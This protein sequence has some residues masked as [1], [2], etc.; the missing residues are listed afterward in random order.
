MNFS[1]GVTPS[2]IKHSEHLKTELFHPES[3]FWKW[4]TIFTYDT[5]RN[6]I[7]DNTTSLCTRVTPWL[8]KRE[9]WMGNTWG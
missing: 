8:K 9:W 4:D 5:P 3:S 2:R 1:N 7:Q 6:T